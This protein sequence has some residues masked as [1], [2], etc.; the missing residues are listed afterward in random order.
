MK[1]TTSFSVEENV[2]LEFK[3]R[4]LDNK[5]EYSEAIETLMKEYTKRK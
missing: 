5:T 4:C 2:L 3:K 1:Q